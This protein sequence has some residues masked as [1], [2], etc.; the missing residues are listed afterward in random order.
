MSVDPAERASGLPLPD[1]P[2]SMATL[3]QLEPSHLR[4]LLKSGLRR[5]ATK[6]QVEEILMQGWGWSIDSREARMLLRDLEDR[7]WFCV[8]GLVW[9]TRFV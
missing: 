7:G 2:L 3:V 8:E 5:G 1:G 9:K 6:D 4:R